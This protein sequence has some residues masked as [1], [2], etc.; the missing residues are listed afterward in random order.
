MNIS[1][2]AILASTLL[3]SVIAGTSANAGRAE[4]PTNSTGYVVTS[5]E[6][7]FLQNARGGKAQQVISYADNSVGIKKVSFQKAKTTEAGVNR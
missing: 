4:L 1:T 5:G 7:I 3:V 6:K 2:K